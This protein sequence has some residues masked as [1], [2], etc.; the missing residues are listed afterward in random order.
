MLLLLRPCG[1]LPD[2]VKEKA[3][4]WKNNAGATLGY[5]FKRVPACS[6]ARRSVGYF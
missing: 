5:A 6:I 2:C 4:T 3:P 1:A